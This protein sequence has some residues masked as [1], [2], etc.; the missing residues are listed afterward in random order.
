MN[1]ATIS[2]FIFLITPLLSFPFILKDIFDKKREGL[3]LFVLFIGI[4]VY[5]FLPSDLMDSARRY[6]LY[7]DFQDMDYEEFI[8][9]L[10]SRS[11]ALFYILIYIFSK[12]NIKFQILLF[13]LGCF[14]VGVPLYVFNKVID[15]HKLTNKIYFLSFFLVF[16]SISFTYIFSGIR[17]LIAFNFILLGFYNCFFLKKIKLSLFFSIL[18]VVTHFSVFIFLP[19]IFG[20]GRLSNKLILIVIS[21]VFIVGLILPNEYKQSLLLSKNTNID[22]YDEKID[23]Y[24]SISRDNEDTTFATSIAKT[25]ISMWFYFALIY[26]Y[27]SNNKKTMFFKIFLLALIPISFLI[28]FPGIAGRYMDFLKMIFALLLIDDYISKKNNKLLFYLT[29]IIIAPLYDVFRL[30]TSSFI[31]IFSLEH[32]TILQILNVTYTTRDL[33]H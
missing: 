11:D 9:Y 10:S 30:M 4:C 28:T 3:I 17:Q 13:L 5:L 15:K 6:K 18:G 19:I 24:S 21:L 29:L 8:F 27:F 33:I 2:R 31:A 1:Q 22:V 23:A 20:I 12:L 26:A 7:E 25:L 32:L 16:F 14:N